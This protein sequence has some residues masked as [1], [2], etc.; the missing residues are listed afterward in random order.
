MQFLTSLFGGSG[1]TILTS[2]FA[3]GVVLVLIFLALWVLKLIFRAS[4]GVG[5][6]RNRRLTVVDSLALDPKR[7]LLIIRRDNV[8]HLIMVGGAQELVIE[9]G[10]G[11]DEAPAVAT[12]RPV[13]TVPTR[14]VPRPAS[15]PVAAA[16]VAPAPMKPATPVI[17]PPPAPAAATPPV[18]ANSVTALDRLRDLNKPGTGRRSVSL[19]HTGLMRPVSQ[20]AVTEN[21]AGAASDSGKEVLNAPSGQTEFGDPNDI[22][23]NDGYTADRN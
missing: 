12:R 23:R 13:P 9:S 20:P 7:Q 5:R 10:I 17:T 18:A 4:G 22:E 16:P 11:V 1:S 14:P 2:V 15:K 8:E 19:R 3:L 6:G 21:P